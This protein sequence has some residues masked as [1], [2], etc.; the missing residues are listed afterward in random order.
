[1]QHA[2]GAEE[3]QALE[4]GVAGTWYSVAVSASAAIG[5]MP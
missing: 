5:I 1:V 3:Q 2:A 4:E